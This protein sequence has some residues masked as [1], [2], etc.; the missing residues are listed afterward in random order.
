[1]EC[2]SLSEGCFSWNENICSVF[3][4]FRYDSWIIVNMMI[5]YS[6]CC[7]KCDR[8]S[9]QRFLYNHLPW[10]LS[11]PLYAFL[12]PMLIAD[13]V[14]WKWSQLVPLAHGKVDG[15]LLCEWH[16]QGYD[17]THSCHVF[18]G[19][20]ITDTTFV[21]L[22]FFPSVSLCHHMMPFLSKYCWCICFREIKLYWYILGVDI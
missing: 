2:C 13:E 17:C 15:L 3:F 8:N 12:H 21:W 16:L 11:R 10:V 4:C 7:W 14:R 22:L 5:E 1:M 9:G 20:A 18:S 6:C 19:L